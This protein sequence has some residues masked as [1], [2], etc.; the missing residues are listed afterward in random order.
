[1]KKYTLGS[2]KEEVLRMVPERVIK[3]IILGGRAVGLVREGERFTCFEEFCPHRGASLI[4]GS[5]NAAGELIC[6]LHA[7]RFELQT[8]KLKS[9]SCRD[10]CVFPVHLS[11]N[12]LEITLP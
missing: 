3:K 12:G 10:L 1:M 6:P 2:S 4:Q 7:Y 8:G 5:L 9:G 11:E